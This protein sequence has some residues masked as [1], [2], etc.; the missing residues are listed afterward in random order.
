VREEAQRVESSL[1]L[2]LAALI[3]PAQ[4]STYVC[5][6]ETVFTLSASDEMAIVRFEDREYRLPR[7]RSAIAIK[8]ATPQATLYLDGD[9]AAFVSD[10]R[11]PP[12]CRRMMG[13]ERGSR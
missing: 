10:D 1:T 5:L 12:G 7:R 2:L 9:F 13:G 3:A 11:W 6:D 4:H 8:Y